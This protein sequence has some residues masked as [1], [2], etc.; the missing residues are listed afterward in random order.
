ML[1]P[2]DRPAFWDAYYALPEVVR[3]LADKAFEQLKAN[4]QYPSLHFKKAGRFLS[5]R[6]GIHHRVIGVEILDGVLWFWIGTHADYDRLI[7]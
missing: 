5:A 7:S 4:P 6:V 3:K 2:P 1:D